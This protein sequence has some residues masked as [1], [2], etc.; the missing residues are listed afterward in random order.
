MTPDNID[1]AILRELQANATA[2][3]TDIAERG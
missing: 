2:T 3:L 1:R